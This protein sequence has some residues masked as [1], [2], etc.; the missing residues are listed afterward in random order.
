MGQIFL[1]NQ[2]IGLLARVSGTQLSMAATYQGQPVRIA[3]GGQMYSA[4]APLALNT[5]T[6]GFG[7]LDAGVL[8]LNTLY[9]VYA[10]QSGGALGLVASINS[11]LPAGFTSAKQ[12]GRFRTFY[13]SASIAEPV[14]VVVG[15]NQRP[16]DLSPVIN[17]TPAITQGFGVIATNKL[18][19]T[20]IGV[21]VRIF[22]Q[23]TTGTVN[24]SEAQ[25]GLPGGLAATLVTATNMI[26]GSWWQNSAAGNASKRGTIIA[27][28]GL[29]YVRF[30]WD[31]YVPTFSPISAL[32]GS[33]IIGSGVIMYLDFSLPI[34]EYVGLFD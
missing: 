18:T 30:G 14:N 34:A 6:V 20:R 7:G 10:V 9:Y 27:T 28:V 26:I 2:N 12:V 22:N 17:F 4:S 31:D 19:Y 24:G 21:G 5:G 1:A 13:A 23:F 29:P 16:T 8:V 11:L 15:Q 3:V 25:L 32:N 33:N